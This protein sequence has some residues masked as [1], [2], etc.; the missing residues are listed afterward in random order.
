MAHHHQVVARNLVLV[1]V[2]IERWSCGRKSG[3][4][5]LLVGRALACCRCHLLEEH[6]KHTRDIGSLL[7]LLLLLLISADRWL[8]LLPLE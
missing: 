3:L 2:E 4:L 1:V 6:C 8:L 5:L 7:I